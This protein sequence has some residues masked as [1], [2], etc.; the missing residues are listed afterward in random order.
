MS[1]F[2]LARLFV[3]RI[4]AVRRVTFDNLALLWHYAVGQGLLGLLLLHGFP[5][6]V[7]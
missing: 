5:R 7:G 6:L 4:D 3:G 1:G 2:L